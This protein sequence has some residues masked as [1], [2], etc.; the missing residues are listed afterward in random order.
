MDRRVQE[1]ERR[2]IDIDMYSMQHCMYCTKT[3]SDLLF[4]LLQPS[5]RES[6]CSASYC[7][8][9]FLL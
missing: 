6:E 2:Q 7:T 4:L 1:A 3:L 8:P 9:L 5:Q